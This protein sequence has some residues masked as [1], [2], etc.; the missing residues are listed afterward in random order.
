MLHLPV[1][2]SKPKPVLF[3]HGFTGSKTEAGR[4]FTDMAR[5]LCSAGYASLRFDFRGHG[6]SP[7]SFEEFRISTAVEDAQNAASHLK[8]L[9]EVDASRL[10]VIGLSMGGG[11]AVKTVAGR[12][13]VAALVLLSAAFHFPDLVVLVPLRQEGGYVYLREGTMRMK[14]ENWLE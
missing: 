12:D 3:L 14:A 1:N 10:A 5:V 6:D 11:V 4:L 9:G 13:D 8:S 2:V 7:L